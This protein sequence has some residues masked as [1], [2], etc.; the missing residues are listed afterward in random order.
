MEGFNEAIASVENHGLLGRLIGQ[1]DRGI[2]NARL[3]YLE[4]GKK[5]IE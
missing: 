4:D 5:R 2:S 3:G 1:R